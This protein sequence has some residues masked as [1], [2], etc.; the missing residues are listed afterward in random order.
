[1]LTEKDRNFLAF[2]RLLRKAN[3]KDRQ[4]IIAFLK[5]DDRRKRPEDILDLASRPKVIC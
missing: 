5:D 2:R 1:M 4:L 3:R